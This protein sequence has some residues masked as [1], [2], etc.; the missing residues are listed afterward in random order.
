MKRGNIMTND[1]MM[2]KAIVNLFGPAMLNLVDIE[3]DGYSLTLYWGCRHP[4]LKITWWED[5]YQI[6]SI[7]PIP[8]CFY[9]TTI[10]GD[11]DFTDIENEIKTHA[12]AA[13]DV[14]DLY[15]Q[16]IRQPVVAQ[17]TDNIVVD[18]PH[19]KT[20]SI[21][22]Q[23]PHLFSDPGTLTVY[24]FVKPS[25]RFPDCLERPLTTKGI[26]SYSELMQFINDL[27]AAEYT[28]VE[29]MSQLI[30]LGFMEIDT[31]GAKYYNQNIDITIWLGL[32]GGR[33][34]LMLEGHAGTK[35]LYAF[36]SL[37]E[38]LDFIIRGGE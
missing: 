22:L 7:E 31:T 27:S 10:C 23:P 16:I 36:N 5:E 19:F 20:D 6:A 9:I 14:V 29:E 32:L 15:Q 24:V 38:I 33:Y 8:N 18:T 34:R 1:M 28:L 25:S 35:K 4:I 3:G 13:W 2:R 17:V 12:K 37:D 30:N 11:S 26:N 21:V